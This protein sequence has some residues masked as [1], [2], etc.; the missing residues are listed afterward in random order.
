MYKFKYKVQNEEP[1]VF[2]FNTLQEVAEYIKTICD[3]KTLQ[4]VL[5]VQKEFNIR[6]Y[7]S[8][9]KN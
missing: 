5:K 9:K 2:Y 8:Y 7:L 3:A 6:F 4:D 1:E